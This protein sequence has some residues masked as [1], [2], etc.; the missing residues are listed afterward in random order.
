MPEHDK[1][2]EENILK[3][4]GTLVNKKNFFLQ[5]ATLKKMKK[6]IGLKKKKIVCF[7]IGGSGRS[8]EIKYSDISS[9]ISSLNKLNLT[10]EIIYLFSR[11]TPKSLKRFIIDK[12]KDAHRYYPYLNLNPYWYLI[13]KSDFFFVTEDSVSMTSEVLSTNKPV[14]IVP[15]GKL[16]K[17]IRFFQNNLLVR[18]YTKKFKGRL[19]KWKYKKFDETKRIVF[20]IKSDL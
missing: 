3:I 19:Y 13:S 2:N 8:S 12:K 9:I 16:K 14:F 4:I 1:F 15:I 17:K 7:L 20:Q 11:R 18:G 5:K 6:T 10:Y